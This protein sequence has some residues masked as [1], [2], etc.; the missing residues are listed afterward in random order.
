V[1]LALMLLLLHLLHAVIVPELHP[2]L[3]LLLLAAVF[4]GNIHS[5]GSSSNNGISTVL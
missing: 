1:L 5:S 4:S 2:L 3:V